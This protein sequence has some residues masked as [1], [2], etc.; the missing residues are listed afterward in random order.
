MDHSFISR[1]EMTLPGLHRLI[2]IGGCVSALLVFV[3]G[4][5]IVRNSRKDVLVEVQ[6]IEPIPEPEVRVE[7]RRFPRNT[8]LPPVP[9]RAASGS[10]DLSSFLPTRDLVRIDHP[11]VWWESDH[12]KGDH[13]NDHIV[14]RS[15]EGPL[16]RLIEMVCEEG[17]TLEVHDAYR[18]EGIHNSHSLHKEGRAVDL[19]CDQF[20]LERL[21]KLCWLAGFDW[22]YYEALPKKGPHVHCS[23]KR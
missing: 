1:K 15:V 16:R 22:V 4:T 9:E 23:V 18:S 5:C 14:H 7:P 17:G 19:T 10:I 20:P 21:A 6:E 3:V 11:D 12:D 13:E 8:H 2:L